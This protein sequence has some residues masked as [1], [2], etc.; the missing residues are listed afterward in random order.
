MIAIP[1]VQFIG[2]WILV[3]PCRVVVPCPASLWRLS[4]GSSVR[5]LA[6]LVIENVLDGVVFLFFMDAGNHR[7]LF[8]AVRSRIG[9]V[10]W[11]AINREDWT[12]NDIDT[13]WIA[14]GVGIFDAFIYD[15]FF[16]ELSL[17]V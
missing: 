5:T 14:H 11:R 10:A 2:S 12:G 6:A 17:L 9:V 3:I 15:N 13:V 4:I 7:A 1:S 16:F 8:Q